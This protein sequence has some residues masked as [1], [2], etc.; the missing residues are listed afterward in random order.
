MS[1]AEKITRAKA[2]YDAVYEAGEK[3]QH[4]VFWDDFQDDG[5][6]TAYNY[7]FKHFSDK[8]FYPKYDINIV[9][10]GNAV[11]ASTQ[12]TDLTTRL[13]E[14]GVTL[15]TSKATTV[16]EFFA[17]SPNLTRVPIFSCVS[18]GANSA[19][20]LFCNDYALIEV[21]KL[22]LKADGSQSL[23]ASFARCY[24]LVT[25]NIEG[26]IGK[27]DLNLQWSTKLSKASIISVINALST[28]T[29]GLTV[30]LNDVAVKRAF[31]TS[32]GANNGNTSTEWQSLIT[33][34]SNWNISLAPNT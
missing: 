10:N 31:E 27:G 8:S 19:I 14:C 17:Y 5:A 1:I 24:E 21:E 12:I 34:R 7:T 29:S 20:Y 9:G 2:D 33:T 22:I 3:S 16:N 6:R 13:H 18:A 11:F 30:T 23:N 4:D 15:D 25:L 28:T 32:S 26:V